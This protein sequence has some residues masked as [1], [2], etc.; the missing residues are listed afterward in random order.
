MPQAVFVLPS[1]AW[2][3]PQPSWLKSAEGFWRATGFSLDVVSGGATEAPLFAAGE[4]S[5]APAGPDACSTR[6]PPLKPRVTIGRT[7]EAEVCQALAGVA[8]IRNSLR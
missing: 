8:N 6:D 5:S 1:M 4:L 7:S 3:M 2:A